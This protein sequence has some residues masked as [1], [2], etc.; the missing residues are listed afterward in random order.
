[1]I[2]IEMIVDYLCQSHWFSKPDVLEAHLSSAAHTGVGVPDVG[3][4]PLA[5]WEK[6]SIY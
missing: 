5:P 6:K 1:M 4:Q 2:L 3:H